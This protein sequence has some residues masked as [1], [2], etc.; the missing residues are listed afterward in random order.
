MKKGDVLVLFA[1][2][3]L[4][5]LVWCITKLHHTPGET[6]VI[7]LDGA[8]YQTLP[9]S[10]DAEVLVNQT[11]TVKISNHEAFMEQ[12]TCPDRLCIH[13]GKTDSPQ[14]TIICLPNRVSISVE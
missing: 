10:E 6:V 13:Q 4:S 5:V 11:N 7:R 2:L 12:A 1:I 9:L 3:F 14:K 8:V